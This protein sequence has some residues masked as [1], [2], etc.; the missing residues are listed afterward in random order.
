MTITQV[1]P[2]QVEFTVKQNMQEGQELNIQSSPTA[3]NDHLSTKKMSQEAGVGP[4]PY[5]SGQLFILLAYS[6][7]FCSLITLLHVTPF[8]P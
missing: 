2:S 8:A 7:Y 6:F 5:L 3:K 1:D 4:Y